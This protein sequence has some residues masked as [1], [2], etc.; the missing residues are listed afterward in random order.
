MR[1]RAYCSEMPMSSPIDEEVAFNAA[2]DDRP[3]VAE[4]SPTPF[5]SREPPT[6]YELERMLTLEEVAQFLGLS[7]DSIRRH[8]AH[9]IRRLSPRRV[10]IKLRDVL[11]I[12]K[13]P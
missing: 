7:E 9:L 6:A 2:T 10:G 5:W 11:T 13:A 3:A 8:Y 1:D 12:G 4:A